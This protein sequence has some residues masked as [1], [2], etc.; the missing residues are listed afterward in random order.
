MGIK[1]SGKKR[2]CSLQAVPPFPSVFKR[3]ILQ[4]RKNPGLVWERVKQ[5]R[6]K[7]RLT[8][9]FED[10]PSSLHT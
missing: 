1:Y 4:T 5:H 7:V 6:A 9:N 2:N 3:L 8:V 10:W